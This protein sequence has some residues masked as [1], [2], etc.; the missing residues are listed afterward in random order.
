MHSNS[1]AHR[2][3]A[4]IIHV[5]DIHNRPLARQVISNKLVMSFCSAVGLLSDAYR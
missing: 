2:K 1:L 3:K 5:G 4:M